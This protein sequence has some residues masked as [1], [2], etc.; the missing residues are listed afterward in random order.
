VVA[1][2]VMDRRVSDAAQVVEDRP[3]RG[4][5]Y[6]SLPESVDQ[7]LLALIADDRATLA[8]ARCA[9]NSPN[10]RSLKRVVTGSRAKCSSA[11]VA[12]ATSR[13]SWYARYAKFGEG[14]GLTGR[15]GARRASLGA[16][17]PE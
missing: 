3:R 4:A 17:E 11:C 2:S 15:P 12:S 10:C 13:A 9:R 16:C 8:A 7:L 6:A 1:D 14:L 5:D